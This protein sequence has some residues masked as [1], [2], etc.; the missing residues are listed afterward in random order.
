MFLKSARGGG[1]V[2]LMLACCASGSAQA[3]ILPTGMFAG[4]LWSSAQQAPTGAEMSGLSPFGVA[5]EKVIAESGDPVRARGTLL[6]RIRASNACL[7]VNMTP[8]Q[9]EELIRTWRDQPESVI[10][11]AGRDR[12]NV[13]GTTFVG[14]GAVGASG[15]ATAVS[16]TYSFPPDVLLW[17]N[18]GANETGPNN[19]NAAI[20][21]TYPS[22]DLAR[23]MIRQGFANYRKWAG[24][25]YTEVS[26]DARPFDTFAGR[27]SGV[28]DIRIGGAVV[29][30]TTFNAYNN[31]PV[32]GSDMF[33]DTAGW[34]AG[35]FANPSSSYLA[36]R[37]FVVH[38]HGHGLGFIHQVPCN[39]TKIMEPLVGTSFDSAQ[40][41]DI[42]A[43]QRNFGDRFSG[44]HTPATAKSFGDITAGPAVGGG[45]SIR[46]PML[47]TN[48]AFSATNPT[49]ADWFRFDSSVSGRTVVFR[50]RPV[51]GSYGTGPQMA[52]PGNICAGASS[53]V[54]AVQ[55]G[56]LKIEVFFID[57]NGTPF[58]TQTAAT[59]GTEVAGGFVLATGT[60]WIRVSD[61]G[62]NPAG[63]QVVQLYD[64]EIITNSVPSDPIA[65]FGVNK[66]VRAGELCVLDPKI[67]SQ[68]TQ[69]GATL[70]AFQYDL[71]ND[72]IFETSGS[73]ASQVFSTP[74]VYPVTVR[75]IDSNNKT[76]DDTITVTVISNDVCN[77]AQQ[78]LVNTPLATNNTGATGTGDALHTCRANPTENSTGVWFRF[79]ANSTANYTFSTCPTSIDT[80]MSVF[81][82][83][84]DTTL[85]PIACNDDDLFCASTNLA[86]RISDLPLNANQA[87]LIKVSGFN[88]A[89]GN[90]TLNVTQT[91]PTGACCN[92]TGL[93]FISTAALCPAP[94]VWTSA[95]VCIPNTC[96]PTNSP[97][98]S[99]ATLALNTPVA[100]TTI[101]IPNSDPDTNFPCTFCQGRGVWFQFTPA[102]STRYTFSTCGSAFFTLLGILP[103]CSTT[104]QL[105]CSYST[106]PGTPN[107]SE[108]QN[109]A[110]IQGVPL[111]AG[112]SY[113]VLLSGVCFGGGNFD[114][115]NYQ[116][117][118]RCTA[119][120]N[121]SG[122]VTVQDI[123]DFLSKWFAGD[124]N[125]DANTSGTVSTQDIFDFLSAWFAGC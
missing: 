51:G 71:N 87:Y 47:S 4:L 68:A 27:R 25:N 29:N 100:G 78:V 66:I 7:N 116:L 19:L 15:T 120:I 98:A 60:H 54:N 108:G 9:M 86:S 11:V 10:G 125:A 50:A 63:N 69:P 24:I 48:G 28:G 112:T 76:A 73:T 105:A 37:N 97:C 40:I 113:R 93:C 70:T 22:T 38:E 6:S 109:R 64:L 104:T 65:I 33:F 124:L 99:P 90:F 57:P 110:Q 117:V 96:V 44:N 1:V 84:C 56:T 101:N 92:P 122:S 74:G 32:N 79:I 53:T 88:G 42:R 103:N 95:G 18:G 2:A 16:V 8:A 35:L 77:G 83:T 91:A 121:Q 111:V 81:S 45:R 52:V 123:F 21:S 62:P 3:E 41:D 107:C 58:F 119:D 31:F 39:A 82:G 34:N 61:V 55:A 89:T 23:E 85:T 36:L 72:G 67:N 115:G 80:V 94:G 49:G 114:A 5:L 26:D 13:D 12:F 59:P 46:Q 75:V 20:S 30:S 43:V 14:N 102:V 118:V 106:N 17:G